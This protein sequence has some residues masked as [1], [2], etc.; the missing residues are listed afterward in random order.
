MEDDMELVT[1]TIPSPA[2]TPGDLVA[3]KEQAEALALRSKA[4]STAERYATCWKTFTAFCDSHGLPYLPADVRVVVLFLTSLVN[5]GK[6]LATIMSHVA[7]IKHYHQLGRRDFDAEHP[8]LAEVMAGIRRTVGKAQR[9]SDALLPD[10]LRKLV[11]SCPAT[12]VGLRDRALLLLGFAGAF[13]QSEIRS[14]E[15]SDLSETDEGLVVFLRRSKTDQ[16][17]EGAEVAI[18]FAKDSNLCPILAL[19]KWLAAAKIT[20]GPIF[21]GMRKGDKVTASA[22]SEEGVRQLVMRAVEAAGLE[23]KITPHSLR[24]GFC[25][26]AAMNGASIEKIAR[27]SRH[28]KLDTTAKYIRIANRFKDHAGDGLL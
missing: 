3:L 11:D 5:G 16:E 12:L 9:G 24:A 10:D 18:P 14:L 22:L 17:G 2:G 21:R 6:A 25:T 4:A 20:E 26:A 13:R 1:T 19:R 28:A 27:H 23:G 15:V 7:A 8:L